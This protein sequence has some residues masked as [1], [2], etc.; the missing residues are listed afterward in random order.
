MQNS[1]IFVNV[2]YKYAQLAPEIPRMNYAC[3]NGNLVRESL[4]EQSTQ[5]WSTTSQ[6]QKLP[7][8]SRD[9]H[10]RREAKSMN[11]PKL[12][13][14]DDFSQHHSFLKQKKITS[15]IQGNKTDKATEIHSCD[16]DGRESTDVELD[17]WPR[18]LEELKSIMDEL[19]E[20]AVTLVFSDG[21]TQL[22]RKRVITSVCLL[23]E[24]AVCVGGTLAYD[25][26]RSYY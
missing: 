3:H 18:N 22:R 24:V 15:Y 12:K 23:Y 14:I 1:P 2:S 7:G 20:V 11:L 26:C 10:N 13:H 17:E 5:N 9:R 4:G 21:S 19:D 16:T 8:T 25:Y 6:N